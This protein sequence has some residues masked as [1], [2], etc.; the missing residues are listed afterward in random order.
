MRQL[1]R[2]RFEG[3]DGWLW[4]TRGEIKASNDRIL[5]DKLPDDAP[6]VYESKN[7]MGNFFDCI[8]SRKETICPAEI[9]HRSATMCHLGV[10]A[11]RLGKKVNYDPVKEAF[12]ND[13]EAEKMA[14][15]PMREGYDYKSIGL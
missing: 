3:S 14:V 9:G 13:P 7:H 12:V 2:L 11:I 5:K 4:V 10:L 1:V 15:R 8:R 6:R